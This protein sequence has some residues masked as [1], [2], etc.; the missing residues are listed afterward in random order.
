MSKYVPKPARVKD[1]I[2]KIWRKPPGAS[3]GTLSGG[4]GISAQSQVGEV[5]YKKKPKRRGRPDGA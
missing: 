4:H 2:R 1:K 5:P 3:S